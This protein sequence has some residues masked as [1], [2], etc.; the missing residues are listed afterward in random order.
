MLTW[1]K[2]VSRP[3]LLLCMVTCVAT[4]I[5]LGPPIPFPQERGGPHW[6]M[7][8][9]RAD[10][11]STIK[12]L[13]ERTGLYNPPS[14]GTPPSGR[15]SG[16]AGRGP[17]CALLE[18]AQPEA[19]VKALMPFQSIQNEDL[20][21]AIQATALEISGEVVGG[22]TSAAQ[23]TF[24]FYV[25]YVSTMESSTREKRV[26]QFVLLDDADRPVWHELIAFELRDKPQ[27]V[28]YSLPYELTPEN[29][30]Q[31]HFSVI[32]DPDKRSRNPV[33]RGW[34]QRV[35]APPEL[36]RALAA[37]AP[38]DWHRLYAESGLWFETISSLINARRSFPTAGGEDWLTLM[39]YLEIPNPSQLNP[40]EPA[41]PV[42][43][44]VVV[45]DNQFPARM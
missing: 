39:T 31:W 43:T 22:L 23:P 11:V 25:P 17:I 24:W 44:E 18:G 16:G 36:D 7:P 19:S 20:D 29:L 5:L 1:L 45:S 13:L 9:A 40:L 33:V 4:S 6:L 30:Y 42:D 3:I 32:C 34:V 8:T 2:S 37:T 10:V 15:R 38:V 41:V 12:D 35:E 26:A 14:G 21:L 27:L 28:E